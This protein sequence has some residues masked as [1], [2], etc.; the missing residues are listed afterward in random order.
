MVKMYHT[1]FEPAV[2]GLY[3]A[4]VL[5]LQKRRDWLQVTPCFYRGNSFEEDKTIW[6]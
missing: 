2:I 4:V 5:E 1:G 3:R 6:R